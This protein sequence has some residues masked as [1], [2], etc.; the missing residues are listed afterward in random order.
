MFDNKQQEMTAELWFKHF[1]RT[2][3]KNL[4]NQPNP[5]LEAAK[6][7]NIKL[8]K[9]FHFQQLDEFFGP[10]IMHSSAINGHLKIVIF[11]NE[12]RNEGCL[13]KTTINELCRST[14]KE[15]STILKYLYCNYFRKEKI[16]CFDKTSVLLAA[17][18][19]N[20]EI[21]DF[22]RL[23]SDPS[24]LFD[25]STLLVAVR[26]NNI[27]MLKWLYSNFP[28]IGYNPEQNTCLLDTAASLGHLDILKW[29]SQ[30]HH[31]E[32]FSHD[33]ITMA[34][35]SGHTDVLKWLCSSNQPAL[36]N[37]NNDEAL[38]H[39]IASNRTEVISFLQMY[40][41]F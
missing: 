39:A 11:L 40:S 17:E 22:I 30:N 33:A 8:V 4:Y 28:N 32:T 18:K 24:R 31:Q 26:T 20:F 10:E 15:A 9:C 25:R 35:F 38:R 14:K 1:L 6:T 5:L 34:A 37:Y 27:N 16:S 21:L 7:G 19:N 41:C 13:E 29:F 36:A 12:N 23:N 3:F 2:N